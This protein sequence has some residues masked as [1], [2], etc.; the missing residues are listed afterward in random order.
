MKE[1][2]LLLVKDIIP[3]YSNVMKQTAV[4]KGGSYEFKRWHCIN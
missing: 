3:V 1:R 4:Q 2:H